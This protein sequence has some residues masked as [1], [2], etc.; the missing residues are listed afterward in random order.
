MGS[1][2]GNRGNGQ[3]PD[4]R[5]QTLSIQYMSKSH[6]YLTLILRKNIIIPDK[7]AWAMKAQNDVRVTIRV[8]K[9]LKEH[10]EILFS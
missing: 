3:L 2:L 6:I 7:E 4:V 8:E 5:R 1:G 9:D 10:A